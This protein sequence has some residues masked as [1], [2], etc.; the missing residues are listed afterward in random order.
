MVRDAAKYK[1][2]EKYSYTW[3]TELD[4]GERYVSL[5]SKGVPFSSVKGGIYAPD[6]GLTTSVLDLAA[7]RHI[8]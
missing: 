7:Y 6:S 5:G 8:R 4:Q 1:A 2:M 3:F